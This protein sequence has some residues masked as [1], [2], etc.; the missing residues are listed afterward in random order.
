MDVTSVQE[1]FAYVHHGVNASPGIGSRVK[2]DHGQN[3]NHNNNGVDATPRTGSRVKVGHVQNRNHN[4]LGQDQNRNL[5]YNGVDVSPDTGARVKV[6]QG[7]SLPVE[8]PVDITLI[9]VDEILP[10]EYLLI[11]EKS[12]FVACALL[13]IASRLYIKLNQPQRIVRLSCN[14]NSKKSKRSMR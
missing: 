9:G 10:A 13:K 12:A 6:G 2:V 1:T 8:I 14:S 4:N 7:M 3:R 5:I 11:S